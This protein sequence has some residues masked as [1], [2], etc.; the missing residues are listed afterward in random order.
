[1]S[2]FK[3]L[4][5]ASPKSTGSP[6]ITVD[7]SSQIEQHHFR[8]NA[9][10]AQQTPISG[11]GKPEGWTI[12]RKSMQSG[13][14]QS[15]DSSHKRKRSGS[16]EAKRESY[17]QEKTP[18]TATATTSAQGRYIYG[19]QQERR[20]LDEGRE[21]SSW[22]NSQERE[23]RQRSERRAESTTS[24]QGPTDEQAGEAS[25]Q[26][27]GHGDHSDYRGQSSDADDPPNSAYPYGSDSRQDPM[28]QHDPK[29]RKRNFSNRTKTGCLTCRKRKKKCDEEKPEC[30]TQT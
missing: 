17:I 24:T 10:T 14:Y 30:K 19:S 27:G 11:S 4:N 18:D 23:D 6:T 26:A 16:L 28:L 22:R 21:K 8:Q 3:A 20:P 25:Q 9:H 12:D 7:T 29:K 15:L 5:G 13:D 1:M 2:G